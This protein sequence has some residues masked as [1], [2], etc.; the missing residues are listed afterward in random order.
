[1][2]VVGSSP[3]VS[4]WAVVSRSPSSARPVDI[5]RLGQRTCRR[6]LAVRQ[7]RLLS[8]RIVG[9]ADEDDK[10]TMRR[11]VRPTNNRPILQWLG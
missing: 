10:Q 8:M 3:S 1:M 4:G 6:E 2:N 11:T 9:Y 5:V 7:S